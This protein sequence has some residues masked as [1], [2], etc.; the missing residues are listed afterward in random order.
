MNSE[1]QY[2]DLFKAQRNVICGNSCDAM[3]AV[4]SEAFERFAAAGFPS[5]KNELYKYTDIDKAF[6][7]DYGL[8]LRRVKFPINPYEAFRCNVPNMSTS[9]YFVEND[10]FYERALP[11]A[12]LPQGVYVGSLMKAAAEMPQ[13]VGKYYA[14][15]A[16]MGKDPV[17]ALN[18]MFAQDG[19]LVYIPDGVKTERTIQVINI[20]RSDVDLMANRRV[21]IILGENASASLLFCDHD[22][23][24]R[25]FLATEVA[26]VYAGRNSNLEMYSLEQTTLKNKR[27]ASLYLEQQE[28]SHV[29]LNNMTLHNGL[30]RNTLNLKLAEENAT[31]EAY[32]FALEGENRHVDTNALIDHI[33]PHCTSNVLYKYVLDEQSVGAFA[34][35][36]LVRSGAQ[37]TES[38]ETNANL[39]VSEDARMYTQPMLE[40]YADDVKCN[41]GATVG[42]LSEE[43]LF[44]MG[45]RGVDEKEAR[46]LLEYAFVDE[47]LKHVNM[48]PLRDRIARLVEMS[49]RGELSKC[50]RCKAC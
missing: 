38:Q 18:T 43:A 28:G 16:D 40:I 47:V 7:P 31:L 22:N 37:K 6:A 27:F 32:G 36:V 35:K 50:T 3:N 14:A 5:Q 21:L 15:A 39:C 29:V 2:I 9:L 30:T 34:G 45:Q 19:L 11:H 48:Q 33:A 23:D 12:T 41:H 8:N 13:I 17:A 10:A 42:Q 25:N 44:Y 4:R 1:K 24:D 26:E 20:M 46:L 49:F